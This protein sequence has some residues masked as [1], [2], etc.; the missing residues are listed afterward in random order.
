MRDDGATT[1]AP[2]PITMLLVLALFESVFVLAPMY[3]V[4]ANAATDSS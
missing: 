1:V 3:E 4:D 2:V